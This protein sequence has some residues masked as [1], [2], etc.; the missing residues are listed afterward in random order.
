MSAS[1]AWSPKLKDAVNEGAV[2]AHLQ[3]IVSLGSGQLVFHEALCRIRGRVGQPLAAAAFIQHAEMLGLMPQIDL[4]MLEQV[5]ALLRDDPR[6]RVFVNLS[7]SSFHDELVLDSVERLLGNLP[8]HTLGIEITEHTSLRHLDQTMK[9]LERL[10]SLGALIAIDDFGTGFFSFQHLATLPC[11]LVKIPPSLT[12][13]S[14]ASEAIA[15]AI[16]T[17]AHAYGRAVIIEGIETAAQAHTARQL[18]IEYAQGW[19]Y[20]QPVPYLADSDL[21]RL[22]G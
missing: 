16:T 20:G 15:A 19:H 2:E 13:G 17:V 12:I 11:D 6:L 18:G 9:R 5:G 21:T 8:A 1:R 3:P 22:A 7:A 4:R 10:R 14:D